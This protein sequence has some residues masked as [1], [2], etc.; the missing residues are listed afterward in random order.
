M[1]DNVLF[2]RYITDM[3]IRNFN[4]LED[5]HSGIFPSKEDLDKTKIITPEREIEWNKLSRISDN[6]MH[7]LM[8]EIEKNIQNLLSMLIPI[9]EGKTLGSCSSPINKEWYRKMIKKHYFGKYGVSWNM[10]D[11][12]YHKFINSK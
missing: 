11:E 2:A 6:E 7:N 10:P 9:F 8:L 4:S 1:K 5:L 12:E 3:C